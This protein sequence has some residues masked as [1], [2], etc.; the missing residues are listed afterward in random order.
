[1]SHRKSS[2]VR[3]SDS[4]KQTNP[5]AEL[6]GF[7]SKE[8]PVKKDQLVQVSELLISLS[9][10]FKVAQKQNDKISQPFPSLNINKKEI[11]QVINFKSPLIENVRQPVNRMQPIVSKRAIT[12]RMMSSLDNKIFDD[13]SMLSPMC[14]RNMGGRSNRSKVFFSD[15]KDK[16]NAKRLDQNDQ[17]PQDQ[18]VAKL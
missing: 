18:N 1:M 17:Q 9:L 15:G 11:G 4:V 2:V 10:P 8:L 13:A 14:V 5:L 16:S 12:D 6:I 7:K 3:E